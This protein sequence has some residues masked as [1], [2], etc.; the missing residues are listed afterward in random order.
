M[1]EKSDLHKRSIEFTDNDESKKKIKTDGEENDI[2]E[3]KGK[4]SY[5]LYLEYQ[6]G[7]NK[8]LKNNEEYIEYLKKDA[9]R[10][11]LKERE[12]EK[13]DITKKLLDDELLYSTVK[14]EGK[15]LKELQF[16][17][18]IYNIAKENI[19]LREKLQEESYYFQQDIDKNKKT[20][21][22][23]NDKVD[24]SL[25]NYD[26]QILNKGILKFGSAISKQNIQKQNNN[27]FVF[28]DDIITTNRKSI[29]RESFEEK[30]MNESPTKKKKKK[31]R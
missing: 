23:E 28:D 15:D 16:S 2:M 11:Y 4:D 9:R 17:K 18:K 30:K 21:T 22:Y 10:K 5:S 31:K 25:Y 27:E 20:Q 8:K 19:N 29:K 13:L 6:K 3:S 26:E 1:N 24:K 14:L 7:R 12:K